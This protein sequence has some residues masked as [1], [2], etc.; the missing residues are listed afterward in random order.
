M[1]VFNYQCPKCLKQSAVLGQSETD[2]SK[3][4]RSCRECGTRL[5]RAHQP[6]TSKSVEILDNGLMA[7]PVERLTNQEELKQQ[8][9]GW[10]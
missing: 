3:Q 2:E 4:E 9:K 10:K 8:Q 1:P 5:E 6:L 7:R